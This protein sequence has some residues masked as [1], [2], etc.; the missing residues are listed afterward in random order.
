[1]SLGSASV[2]D[3]TILLLV[4]DI[5]ALQDHVLHLNMLV[6]HVMHLNMLLYHV[7]ILT[8]LLNHV[9]ILLRYWITFGS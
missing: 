8:M 3:I 5:F 6:D 7:W 2:S 9:W 1:M 4:G